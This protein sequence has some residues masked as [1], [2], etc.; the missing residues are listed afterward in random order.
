MDRLE[1]IYEKGPG[2][3]RDVF[4]YVFPGIL[5][6]F[7]VSLSLVI[8]SC[9]W[10]DAWK[11][12]LTSFCGDFLQNGSIG[13]FLIMIFLSLLVFGYFM[14][15]L[16]MEAGDLL[17]WFVR[18]CVKEESYAKGKTHDDE[19]RVAVGSPIIFSYYSERLK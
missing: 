6:L 4:Q 19:M 13:T 5:F 11:K 16:F 7:F 9:V 2:F 8:Y 10:E 12:F 17:N 14:G 15:V 1:R 3:L 18:G